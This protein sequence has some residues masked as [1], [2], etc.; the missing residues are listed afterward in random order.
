MEKEIRH[1]MVAIKAGTFSPTLRQALEQAE[2]ERTRLAHT[3][4]APAKP[5]GTLPALLPDLKVWFKRAVGDIAKMG[6]QQIDKARGII[7][8]LVGSITLKPSTQGGESVLVAHLRPDYEG[9]ARQLVGPEI[10]LT[11]VFRSEV[12]Y[13]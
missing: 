4:D 7:K 1:I 3:L 5:N 11:T 2:P 10:I 13:G 6:P 8:D 9:L 12:Q